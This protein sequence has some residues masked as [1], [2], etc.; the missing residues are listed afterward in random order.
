MSGGHRAGRDEC[1]PVNRCEHV[2]PGR[3]PGS[4]IGARDAPREVAEIAH[5]GALCTGVRRPG[6]V[7][8]QQVCEDERTRPTVEQDVMV[9]DHD[10]DATRVTNRHDP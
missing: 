1:R 10:R 3:Q 9:G 2:T 8:R 7:E 5:P 4:V 6:G